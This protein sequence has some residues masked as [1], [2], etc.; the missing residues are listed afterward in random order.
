MFG[1]KHHVIPQKAKMLCAWFQ[2]LDEQMLAAFAV[3][4]QQLFVS[5]YFC[6]TAAALIDV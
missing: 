4:M 1:G 5:R 2:A 3:S 6:S